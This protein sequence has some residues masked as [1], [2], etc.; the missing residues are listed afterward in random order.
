MSYTNRIFNWDLD[1][2]N[3]FVN[4]YVLGPLRS[5]V[6]YYECATAAATAAKTVT[7]SWF[8][9]RAGGSMKIKMTYANTA[10]SGVTLNINST[11][12]KS[13]YYDGAAVSASNTWEAGETIEV[14]YDGTSY[15]ANNVAGGVGDGVFDL[16]KH[17]AVGGVLATYADLSAALTALNA[18]ESKYKYGGMSFKF[19]QSSDNNYVQWRYMG[20]AVTGNPNPFLDTANW[21]GVDC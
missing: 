6:G 16:S 5:M 3:Y 12:A 13:L 20:T 11:G 18:L 10:A 1:M 19:V 21:Q 4:K 8:T 17:N 15:Y 14:Y 9:L 7:A 2:L